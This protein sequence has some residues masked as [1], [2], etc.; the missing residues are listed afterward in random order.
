MA[1]INF[2]PS[3][4]G[5]KNIFFLTRTKLKQP[6]KHLLRAYQSDV[7]IQLHG[8]IFNVTQGCHHFDKR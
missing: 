4:G 2:T 3:Q 6:D 1:L 8:L 7:P 5:K